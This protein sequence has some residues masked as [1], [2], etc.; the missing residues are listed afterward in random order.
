M[1]PYGHLAQHGGMPVY[2]MQTGNGL[3]GSLARFIIPAFKTAA[4]VAAPIAKNV[5]K[6]AAKD[7]LA[8]GAQTSLELLEGKR[9]AW[10]FCFQFCSFLSPFEN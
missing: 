1:A 4:R 6:T 9:T 3:F 2:T 10:K 7:L 8:A 5:A